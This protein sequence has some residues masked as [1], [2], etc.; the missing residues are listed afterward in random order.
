MKISII[1][2]SIRPAGLEITKK[3]L[4]EQTFHRE[5][6]E[7]LVDINYTNEHDLNQAFNR[8]LKRSKGEL[9]VILQDY[10]KIQPDALQRLWEAYEKDKRTFYTCPVGK[11]SN[12][13]YSGEPK[14]DWRTTR[15]EPLDFTLWEADFACAPKEALF[16]IGGFD[17]ELDKYWSCDNINV[18]CRADIAG[19]KFGLLKDIRGVAYDHDAFIA[20][21]FRSKYHPSF[22]NDRMLA[23]RAGIKI[24]YLT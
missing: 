5:S 1:T 22:N 8:L 2:P 12:L 3:C 7:W 9:I 19:Y 11:V 14:W 24:D 18:G 16:K 10:I 15:N 21:P 17:E 23:F 4:G 20:H 13:D 6:F